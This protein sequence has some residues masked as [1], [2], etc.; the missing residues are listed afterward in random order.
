[1]G[2]FSKCDLSPDHDALRA[3]ILHEKSKKGGESPEDLAQVAATQQEQHSGHGQQECGYF[4]GP[5]GGLEVERA[6]VIA[7]NLQTLPT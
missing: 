5:T 4:R 7:L 6:V 3:R 1:M 2:V